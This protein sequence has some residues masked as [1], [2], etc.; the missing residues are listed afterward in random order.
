MVLV[1][2]RSRHLHVHEQISYVMIRSIGKYVD[3]AA[4]G[5]SSPQ[6]H[7][8][9]SSILQKQPVLVAF[10]YILTVEG[11]ILLI[12]R[13]KWTLST[14]LFLLNRYLTIFVALN[15]VVPYNPKVSASPSLFLPL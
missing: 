5:N 14:L 4:L 10:E 6:N 9:M 3:V 8:I 2:V 7:G 12:W 13:R 15:P 1:N 11:E